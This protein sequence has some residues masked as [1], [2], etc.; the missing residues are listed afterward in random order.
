LREL[1]GRRAAGRGA[2]DDIVRGMDAPSA[3]A[4]RRPLVIANPAAGRGRAGRG[5]PQLVAAVRGT[6]GDA[7]VAETKRRGD[8]TALAAA[9]AREGRPLVISLGGD[10]TLDEIVNGLLGGGGPAGEGVV[11]DRPTGGPTGRVGNGDAALLPSLGIV[12]TGTGGDFGRSLGIPHE[13]GAYLAALRGGAERA[14]DVGWARFPDHEGQ[15][16]ERYWINVLSAGVG[17]LVDRYTATAPSFLGG[18]AAYAQATLRAIVTCRRE[19]LLCRSVGPDGAVDERLVHAHAVAICNGRTFGGGMNVAPMA[20]LDDGLLEVIV[21]QTKTKLQMIRRF[22]TLYAGTHLLEPGV[23]HFSCREVELRPLGPPAGRR[24][25][26]GLFPLDVD[27][28]ALG[29][30]PVSAGLAPAALRFR[31]PVTARS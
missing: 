27:G 3:A 31:A 7:D 15:P 6:V 4:A 11:G 10:G 17:G 20:R 26:A 18:R 12:G 28:D 19:R 25:H 5:L 1:R 29:D 24:P 13:L 14:V 22:R 16:V 8:A 21:F 30:V 23:D 2:G 9:A